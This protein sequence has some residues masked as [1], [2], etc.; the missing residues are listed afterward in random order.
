[1]GL[2]RREPSLFEI[3]F[4][5]GA[6]MRHLFAEIVV[7]GAESSEECQSTHETV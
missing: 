1:M 7:S 2:V 5:Q 4:D 3:R 6:V